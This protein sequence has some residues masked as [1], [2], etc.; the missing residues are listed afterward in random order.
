MGVQRKVYANINLAWHMNGKRA[1]DLRTGS[2]SK[3]EVR[4]GS[5]SR[6]NGKRDI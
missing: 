3:L 5:A 6:M 4:L 2:R 1:K